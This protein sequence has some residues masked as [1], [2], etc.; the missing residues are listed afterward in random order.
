MIMPK[1]PT[2]SRPRFWKI[3]IGSRLIRSLCP[4][5]VRQYEDGEIGE[6]S[7]EQEILD[8][9]QKRIAKRFNKGLPRQVNL[10][11][12][13]GEFFVRLYQGKFLER[14]EP[15]KCREAWGY[16]YAIVRN[17]IHEMVRKRSANM[18][19]D[20]IAI[21]QKIAVGTDPSSA[22]VRVEMLRVVQSR[23]LE[24]PPRQK[25]AIVVIYP[26]MDPGRIPTS[27]KG[28]THYVNLHRAITRLRILANPPGRD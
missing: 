23:Y 14:Y 28:K 6:E 17:I 8:R 20:Q 22:A 1:V 7:A 26:F 25:D 11:D 12:V 3:L 4:D 9:L 21:E 10:G 16:I 2:P 24:L 13:L 19:S 27:T 5:E 15:K 18:M